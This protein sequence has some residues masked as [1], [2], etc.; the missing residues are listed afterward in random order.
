MWILFLV[1]EYTENLAKEYG[2]ELGLSHIYYSLAGFYDYEDNEEKALEYYIEALSYMLKYGEYE[3]IL[4]TAIY[5]RDSLNDMP[6]GSE[7]KQ[8]ATALLK[9][10][11]EIDV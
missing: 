8:K 10:A 6:D 7:Q 4:D 5:I 1:W 9:Q 2:I 11:E 3:F